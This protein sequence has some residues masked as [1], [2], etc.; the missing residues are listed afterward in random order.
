M[1]Q[2]WTEKCKILLWGQS[3]V[4]NRAINFHSNDLNT[5]HFWLGHVKKSK[6]EPILIRAMR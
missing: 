3:E 6:K 5:A 4:G 1:L 2:T